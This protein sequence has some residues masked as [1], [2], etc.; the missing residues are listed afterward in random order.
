[1]SFTI[2]DITIIQ[3]VFGFITGIS[4]L[5]YEYVNSIVLSEGEIAPNVF[6]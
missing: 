5:Y 3:K 6:F 2:N 1:M 4:K